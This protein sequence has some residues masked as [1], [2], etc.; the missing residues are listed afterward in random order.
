MA[1]RHFSWR[2]VGA[3][4]T[5]AA[6]ALVSAGTGSAAWPE[7]RGNAARSGSAGWAAEKP[8]IGLQAPRV[9][10]GSG[11]MY[12]PCH[13]LPPAPDPPAAPSPKCDHLLGMGY[14][15]SY[16]LDSAV[17]RPR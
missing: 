8:L 12:I 16:R 6:V 4:A 1:T 5:L 9:F 15:S 10:I 2:L 13:S 17:V 14:K 11:A 7:Y 3:A